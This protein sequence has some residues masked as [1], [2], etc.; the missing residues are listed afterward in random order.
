MGYYDEWEDGR[1][2]VEMP[3]EEQIIDWNEANDYIND[4]TNEFDEEVYFCDEC[5]EELH[6]IKDSGNMCRS[7]QDDYDQ[8]HPH[9][10]DI[11]EREELEDRSAGLD[12]PWWAY[13]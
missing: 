4:Y 5:G 1:E 12:E 9:P 13:R 10:L 6:P 7:C 2:W 3:T 11:A 8:R